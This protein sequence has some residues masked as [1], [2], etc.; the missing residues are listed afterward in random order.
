VADTF[1][2]SVAFNAGTTPVVSYLFEL[3]FDHNVV[4]VLDIDSQ[5]PFDEVFANPLAF[6][7][8]KVR[9]AASSTTST[10]ALGS[11]TL[12]KIVFQVVGNPGEKS[13]LVLAFPSVPGGQGAIVNNALASIEG[14]TFV[15]G[16]VEVQ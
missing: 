16:A 1:T 13:D 15:K 4:E 9:F 3:S 7:T 11:L 14:V 2:I 10:P 6:P 5:P 12:V 8:G